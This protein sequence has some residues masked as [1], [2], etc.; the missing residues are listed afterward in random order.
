VFVIHYIVCGR[1]CTADKP[2]VQLRQAAIAFPCDKLEG[3]KILNAM[4]DTAPQ[5]GGQSREW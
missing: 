1:R 5:K 3:M 2:A 4:G